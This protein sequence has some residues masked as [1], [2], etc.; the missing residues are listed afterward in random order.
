MA[1]LYAYAGEPWKTQ[2]VV[3][4]IMDEFYT[5]CPDGLIGNEDCGQMSAWYVLSSLG[6]YPVTPG[7]DMYVFG[8]P[9]FDK[10]TIAIGDS[11]KFV[12]KANNNL[13]AN[14]Y[15]KSV[16]LNG[17]E[18]KR[19]WFSHNVLTAGGEITFEMSASPEK[20]FGQHADDRP[21][22]EI[23]YQK[24]VPVPFVETGDRT[25][26]SET[27]LRLSCIDKEAKIFYT[28]D[29]SEPTSTST[30]YSAPVKLDKT[31]VL[32]AVSIKS[33][34]SSSKIIEAVFSKIPKDRKVTYNIRY[35]PQYAAGG[36]LAMIDCVRGGEDFKTGA[37]QGYEGTDFDLVVDLGKP[38]DVVKLSAGCFQDQGAWIWFPEW[39]EFF[40]SA[41][42]KEFKTLG[43]SVCDVPKNKD[44]RMLKDFAI[45]VDSKQVRYIKVIGKNQGN[46]PSWHPGAGG[47][48]WIFVDE[49]TIE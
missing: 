46:C 18:Y 4:R 35:Q 40:A 23:K 16:N 17:N 5:P 32:K 21:F 39:V 36:D 25:F 19:S 37:W 13:K 26:I 31:T 2:E 12:I 1:Y 43:K 15:I 22:A 27:S 28:L 3:R 38:E 44:G 10:A 34:G 7:T 29:G 33:D 48:A 8:S 30:L 20:A 24:I 47:K 9:I 6:F 49:I 42:G 41:D 14:K 11:A 45:A